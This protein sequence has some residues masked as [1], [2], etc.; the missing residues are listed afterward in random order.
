MYLEHDELEREFS[1]DGAASVK[2]YF[3]FY[4]I[5]G[6]GSS[7]PYIKT[8]L[9]AGAGAAAA[10]FPSIEIAPAP[11]PEDEILNDC[12]ERAVEGGIIKNTSFIS[13]Y[14]EHYRGLIRPEGLEQAHVLVFEID[15]IGDAPLIPVILDEIVNLCKIENVPVEKWVVDF[16]IGKPR[17]L[18]L[19]KENMENYEIPQVMWGSAQRSVGGEY[20]Y[21]YYFSGAPPAENAE[22]YAGFVEKTYFLGG[23]DGDDINKEFDAAVICAGSNKWVFKCPLFFDKI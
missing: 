14:R 11:A 22:K 18:Y 4:T 6:A 19:M 8:Y 12:I 1:F 15:D 9:S 10:I 23:G 16:F 2:I 7:H 13:Q 3:Y 17:L 21:F 5:V 20:G